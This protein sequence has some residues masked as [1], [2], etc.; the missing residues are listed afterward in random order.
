MKSEKYTKLFWLVNIGV[1]AL[2]YVFS[3]DIKQAIER[4][5]EVYGILFMLAMLIRYLSDLFCWVWL[6]SGATWLYNMFHS[7]SRVVSLVSGLVCV[8]SYCLLYYSLNNHKNND[9]YDY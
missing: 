4:I 8:V 9:D 3:R 7:Q 5:Y 6:I 2:I 1:V